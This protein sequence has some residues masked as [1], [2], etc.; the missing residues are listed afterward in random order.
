MFKDHV[1]VD[2]LLL[3]EEVED[4]FAESQVE[5]VAGD[6]AAQ[7][8]FV[9]LAIRRKDAPGNQEMDVRV[10]I[11]EG[12]EGLDGRD[13]AR[14]A[15]R[16]EQEKEGREQRRRARTIPDPGVARTAKV[17]LDDLA[18]SHDEL[19]WSHG[20]ASGWRSTGIFLET[21]MMTPMGASTDLFDLLMQR[22]ISISRQ[23]KPR[24]AGQVRPP[25]RVRSPANSSTPK[26]PRVSTPSAQ[27]S[28]L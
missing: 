18:K 4:A 9:E 26:K 21:R 12:A 3:E 22:L 2:R 15:V 1:E 25:R 20:G 7:D 11:E 16:R 23:A 8:W 28:R 17:R 19:G 14:L 13:G 10:R 5:L 6:F 27:R 24:S